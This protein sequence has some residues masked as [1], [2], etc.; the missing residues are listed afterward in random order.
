M[1]FFYNLTSNF[2][3]FSII[4]VLIAAPNIN[5]STFEIVLNRITLTP[6]FGVYTIDPYLEFIPLFLI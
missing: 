1:E 4:I 5:Q 6:W 3:L 2:Q